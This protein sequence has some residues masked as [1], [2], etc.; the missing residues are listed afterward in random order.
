M[1]TVGKNKSMDVGFQFQKLPQII[2]ILKE[3]KEINLNFFGKED[4]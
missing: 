3:C 1:K 2:E 4:K